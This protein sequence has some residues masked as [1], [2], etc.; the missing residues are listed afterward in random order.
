MV[1][2]PLGSKDSLAFSKTSTKGNGLSEPCASTSPNFNGRPHA[3]SRRWRL[4][5]IKV[6]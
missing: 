6:F 2:D 3:T 5:Q 1:P 4:N